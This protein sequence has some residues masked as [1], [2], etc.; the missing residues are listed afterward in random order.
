MRDFEEIYEIAAERK[1]GPEALEALLST[2]LSSAELAAIPD[3][4]WLSMVAKSIFRAGFSWKV[5]ETKWPGFE[6]AF[7]G[8]NVARVASFHDEDMDRL[9]SDK[10]IVRNGMKIAAVL[11]NAHY[12]HQLSNEHGGVGAFVAEWPVE[13][14]NELL[15]ALATG[16]SRLGS[17]TGQRFLRHMGRDSY[18]MTQDVVARLVGEGVID[19][20]PTSRR[21]MAQVQAAFNTWMVQSGRGLT[22]IS[23]TLAMSV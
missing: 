6:T 12:L 15:H 14:H 17:A 18:V 10:S 13:R 22:Q 19:K 20:A 9:L 3:D 4:R 16:G 23:Q 7:K 21:A 8:F 1:G 2:P 5:I 11:E